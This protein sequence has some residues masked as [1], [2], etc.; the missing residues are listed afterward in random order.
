MAR[1]GGAV[2]TG[3]TIST[4]VPSVTGEEIDAV[5]EGDRPRRA[6]DL[7]D[8]EVWGIAPI[9]E[10][11][12]Y[13]GAS[14]I[15]FP[16]FTGN[17]E[18]S[19]VFLGTVAVAFGLGFELGAIALGVGLVLGAIPVALLS[20]WGPRTGTAQVPLARMPFGRSI[21]IPGAIQWLSAIGWVAIGCYFG[22][23]AAQ[24]LLHIPFL[25][26][27]AIV[28]A[29]VAV[30]SAW[31]YEGVMQAEKWGAL[32]MTAL[33]LYLTVRIFQHHVVLPDNT[34]HGGARVGGFV[35]MVAVAISG[36]FSWASYGSDYSRYLLPSSSRSRIFGYT[37]AGMCLSYGWLSFVGLG[38]ASVLGDQTA[39]GIRSLVGGG[40]TDLVL[41]AI[42]CAA[43]FS[44]SMNAYSASLAL[45][46]LNVRLRRPIIAVISV[47]LA[48]VLIWW[49]Y[50]GN[51]DA[52]FTNILLF[53][54]YWLSPFLAIVAIDWLH[55]RTGYSPALLSDAMAWRNLKPGWDALLAF[56]VGFGAMVPF[57]DTSLFV[58]PV[59]KAL[60]G[61]DLAYYVGFVV[62]AALYASLRRI[63]RPEPTQS[64]RLVS[65]TGEECERTGAYVS[66]AGRSRL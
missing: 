12:R 45:Q 51:L 50:S 42:V 40:L 44:S 63:Q 38:A 24:L 5:F 6:G 26:A 43:V 57:M 17:M 56:V 30:I 23:Q 33:F 61:A 21:A 34:V 46:S 22:S 37:M 32:L 59:A 31:G 47:A 48:M 49:M 14:R 20:T 18:L 41:A 35:A 28:L 27:A 9:P 39:A 65:A 52:R 10:S 29:L 66:S 58:G 19:A 53:T 8:L 15:F 7:R 62:T 25:V 64:G 1:I 4:D 16:W 54:G 3:A 2:V 13:G 36:S 11:G 60:S 55:N